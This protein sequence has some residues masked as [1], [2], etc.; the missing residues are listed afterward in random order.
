MNRRAMAAFSR[1]LFVLAVSAGLFA[2]KAEPSSEPPLAGAAIGGAFTLIDKAGKDVRWSQ[3]SGSWRTIYF[4]YTF[5]PDACPT[6]MAVLMKG[7][8][9]FEEKHP[10]LAAKVQPLFVS[11]DPTR[12]GPR[13]VG[14]F[15]AAFHP[16]LIGLTG[17]QAQVDAAAKAFVAY[18]QKGEET[19]GGYLMDHSRQAY[20][21]DPQGKPIALLPIDKSPEA[22]AAELEKWVR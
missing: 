17:T 2:C 4:G 14:E 3:F 15:A 12:D 1:A 11:I 9:M 13:Q 18:Y 19:S 21:M 8:R 20:L 7:F 5:C 10:E 22:V 6:D 16:R